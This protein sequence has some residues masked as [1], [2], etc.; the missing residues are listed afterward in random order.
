MEQM[1]LDSRLDHAI[2]AAMIWMLIPGRDGGEVN[3][4]AAQIKR[5]TELR[6]HVQQGRDRVQS[7]RQATAQLE[8]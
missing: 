7:L 1:E 6:E 8:A 4:M 2:N 5:V 3:M